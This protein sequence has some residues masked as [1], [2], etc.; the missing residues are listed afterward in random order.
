L[1]LHRL[2]RSKVICVVA[3]LTAGRSRLGRADGGEATST[4]AVARSATATDPRDAGVHNYRRVRVEGADGVIVTPE[5]GVAAW[6]PDEGSIRAFELGLAKFI[7]S[8]R[9]PE[10]PTLYVD[11]PKYKRQY[12]G[13]LRRGSRVLFVVLA[14]QVPP[15]WQDVVRI[16]KD[17]SSCFFEVEYD[18]SKR[19][20]RDL[21]VH[22]PA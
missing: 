22:H 3:L 8:A 2:D 17:G 21:H 10:A 20:Y 7:R 14:C 18:V 15:D 12:I 16:S 13:K 1:R 5:K 6:L 4:P 9:P 11:L 19:I